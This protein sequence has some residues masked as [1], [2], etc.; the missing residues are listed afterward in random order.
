MSN[1]R[2]SPVKTAKA[3]AA[4][5][6]DGD[7]DVTAYMATLQHP[8]KAE[9]TSVL[10]LIRNAD[11]AIAAGIKWNAPSF[12]LTEWFATLNV[13][14]Q[15]AVQIILHLGAKSRDDVTVRDAVRVGVGRRPARDVEVT[16][17]RECATPAAVV[18]AVDNNRFDVLVLDGDAEHVPERV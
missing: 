14:S 4:P 13:R 6:G 5:K 2:K 3:P 1:T 10:A 11:P 8:L 12:R 7:E 18:E 16:S 15:D 17:W 9:I